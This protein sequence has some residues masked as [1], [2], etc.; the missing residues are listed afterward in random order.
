[1]DIAIVTG[2]SSSLG[3]AI[4]R[5]LMQL[6]FRVY[7]LGG[8]YKD[9]PLQNVNFKPV[10]CDLADPVAIDAAC[11]RILEKEKGIY[12]LINNAKFFGRSDTLVAQQ[13]IDFL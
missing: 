13:L 10:N 2:A 9:C 3:L 1:M 8:E 6:G 7:G 5:R 12:V 11:K 4:S